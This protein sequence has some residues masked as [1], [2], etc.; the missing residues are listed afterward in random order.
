ME[1]NGYLYGLF[2]AALLDTPIYLLLIVNS[3]TWR[4]VSQYNELK[5]VKVNH[6]Y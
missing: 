4:T 5:K 1:Y 6:F 3:I 2:I